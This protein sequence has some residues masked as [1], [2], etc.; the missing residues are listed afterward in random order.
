MIG[1]LFSIIRQVI[2]VSTG[3]CDLTVRNLGGAEGI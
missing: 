2:R 3:E 1:R